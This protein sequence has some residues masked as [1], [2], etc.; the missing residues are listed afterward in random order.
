MFLEEGTVCS[1]AQ[2]NNVEQC[3][4]L[5]H[6]YTGGWGGSEDTIT[7]AKTNGGKHLSCPSQTCLLKL[8]L[9]SLVQNLGWH[10]H[11]DSLTN[12]HNL[13]GN[14]NDTLQSP[15]DTCR[16]FQFIDTLLVCLVKTP[17]PTPSILNNS[18]CTSNRENECVISLP[19]VVLRL[20]SDAVASSEWWEMDQP[21]L[22]SDWFKTSTSVRL[23]VHFWTQAYEIWRKPVW[24]CMSW[25]QC[26][27]TARK[28]TSYVK[29]ALELLEMKVETALAVAIWCRGTEI[30]R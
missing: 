16:R 1:H 8:S 3:C 24:S 12:M 29:V 17:T 6:G 18:C 13:V 9:S 2:R 20:S 15:L 23:S 19:V 27:K 26:K 30:A 28:P 21:L 22:Q 7:T 14:T 5:K 11:K 4:R 10:P 25:R